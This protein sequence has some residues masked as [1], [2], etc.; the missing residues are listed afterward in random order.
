MRPFSPN[1][2]HT[3]VAFAGLVH[4]DTKATNF[5][6]VGGVIH[7]IDLD[8]MRAPRTQAGLR[9]GI[10]RDLERFIAN[11]NDSATIRAALTRAFER[12]TPNAATRKTR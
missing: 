2:K 5:V 8:A 11:W 12:L 9:R 10:A 1:H 6:D 4:G 3:Y 7:L